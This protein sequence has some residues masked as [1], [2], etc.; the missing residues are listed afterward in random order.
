MDG[1][2]TAGQ[3]TSQ[4][5][6]ASGGESTAAAQVAGESSAENTT[7]TDTQASE[8]IS[9][10]DRAK[11]FF[12][13]HTYENDSQVLDALFGEVKSKREYA[14]KNKVANET[15]VNVLKM[16]PEF[17]NVI[18]DLSKGADPMVAFARHFDVSKL[19]PFEG[20]PNYDEW[21]K[22]N[23]ERLSRLRESEEY[24]TLI[25]TNRSESEKALKSFV[26]ANQLSEESFNEFAT[27]VDETLDKIN[28]GLLDESV[29][30]AFWRAKNYETDIQNATQNGEIKGRNT[31]IEVKKVSK[32]QGDNLPLINAGGEP[33][34]KMKEAPT[35]IDD[36]L[37]FVDKKQEIFSDKYDN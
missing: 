24:R 16:H 2:G 15:L 12:P 26:D 32:K 30:N 35:A 36:V 14:E 19:T 33:K 21:Q 31:N 4:A 8:P 29:L 13:D 34:E 1:T 22:A 28:K 37:S 11:E 17:G 25:E 5:S 10:I 7:P 3:S 23:E 27:Y 9:L 18:K 6:Q 20:D